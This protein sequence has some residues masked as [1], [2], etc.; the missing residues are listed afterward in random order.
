[1]PAFASEVADAVRTARAREWAWP[2]PGQPRS[3]RW[4][5]VERVRTPVPGVQC[6]ALASRAA[7]AARCRGATRRARP[8]PRRG[9]VE[10][11]RGAHRPPA[12][13]QSRPCA[14]QVARRGGTVQANVDRAG[15]VELV[16][17]IDGAARGQERED[18]ATTESSPA[19]EFCP[20]SNPN[21]RAGLVMQRTGRPGTPQRVCPVVRHQRAVAG[22][23]RCGASSS[24]SRTSR[25]GQVNEAPKEPSS[26]ASSFADLFSR[27]C[28]AGV[29]RS[30][31]ARRRPES[32]RP[33]P[34]PPPRT[35]SAPSL[36]P[37]G[38]EE[39]R[40][41]NRSC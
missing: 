41:F 13:V 10:G 26:G 29:V 11:R 37:P 22:R 9:G 24:R 30:P 40:A 3:V 34:S 20:V 7:R 35:G 12:G 4:G 27:V 1:M 19:T 31:C 17:D 18:A 39:Q 2:A 28:G 6:A 8:P 38:R 25:A 23:S 5:P 21:E 16:R 33:H 14:R 32:A 36:C 15:S